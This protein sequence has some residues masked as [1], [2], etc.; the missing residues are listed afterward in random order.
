MSLHYF[1][2]DDQH[3]IRLP[4]KVMEELSDHR[5]ALPH[6]AGKRI[7]VAEVRTIDD[8]NGAP[9]EIGRLVGFL[10]ELDENGRL[11]PDI[12]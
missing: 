7:R 4:I 9:Q 2:A 8:E 10:L 6:Y 11:P 1:I 12:R 3:L 5:A